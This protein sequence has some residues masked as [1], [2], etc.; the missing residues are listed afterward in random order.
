MKFPLETVQIV[1][2]LLTIELVNAF[3][4]T[5]LHTNDLHSR[6][7]QV[8]ANGAECLSN[9]NRECFG[10]V[11]RLK[12]QVDALRE[13]YPNSVFLNAGDFFQG[14][15][16]YS[17]FKWRVVANLTSSLGYDASCLGNHEFDDG[18][19]DLEA[20]SNAI[21][22]SYP[23][24]A[25]NIDVTQEPGLKGKIKPYIIKT[26]GRQKIAIIGYVTPDT[27]DLSNTGNV[28]LKDEILSIRKVVKEVRQKGVNI[29]I[30]LGHSGYDKDL[31][32]AKR[33]EGLDVV[34]GGHTNTFLW[35]GELPSFIP[36]KHIRVADY[37]TV[38]NSGREGREK[39]LVV[40]TN[41]Y[42]RYLGALHVTFDQNGN[43]LEWHGNPILLNDSVLRDEQLQTLVDKYGKNVASKMDTVVGHSDAY[44]DG[45]RP[46]CRIEE[47]SFGNFVTDAMAS[48]MGVDIA[49]INSG[50]IKGSF[51][52]ARRNG[53]ITMHDIHTAM[54]WGNTIDVVTITG[55]T[56][57]LVLE[58]SVKRYKTNDPD[59]SG[60]FLQVSGLTLTYDIS[61][62]VG[63]RLVSGY[64]GHGD[65][66]MAI[67][68]EAYYQISMP[69]YLAKGGDNFKMIPDQ[70]ISYKNTGFLDNDLLVKYLR[71]KNPLKL[72]VANRIVVNGNNSGYPPSNSVM[73]S[74][75]KSFPHCA[76]DT[77][78]MLWM[79]TV[80]SFPLIYKDI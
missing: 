27:K 3:Q 1:L 5:V 19:A 70:T 71:K 58:H 17:M 23:L 21:E 33:V 56:L 67:Q 74:A 66:L 52:P 47:C 48:E 63:H 55:H 60:R 26:V 77:I 14:T 80:C 76:P 7:D 30:A 25:C 11:A 51:D 13:K 9:Q 34:I 32:I 50:A 31:E 42:G 53:T 2:L 38:V 49:F 20:F 12:Y 54:P 29:I 22:D 6:F 62:P 73:S 78:F 45:G 79:F 8:T 4:L 24:L 35:K 43:P 40:Q 64:T 36:R 10:G 65:S 75:K 46:K 57:K 39:S 37:P 72:P 18:V 15:V 44:I 59:P 68:D 61:K 28:V 69:S 41:G 16:W